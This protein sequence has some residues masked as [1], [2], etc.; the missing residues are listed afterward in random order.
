[1]HRSPIRCNETS[2]LIAWNPVSQKPVWKVP[3]FGG[4]NGGV[5]ATAGNLVFQGQID[6][7]VQR[8]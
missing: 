2:A 1:M 8:L 7:Q 3:T 5:L 4:W 6:G